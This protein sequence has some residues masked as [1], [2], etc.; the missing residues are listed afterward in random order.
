MF[1]NI[2]Q[3]SYRNQYY[4][5]FCVNL[6][7]VSF[8]FAAGWTAPALLVLS[9]DESPLPSGKLTEQEISNVA[10]IFNL[11][12]FFGNFVHAYL[13]DRYVGPHKIY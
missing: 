11:G 5:T 7:T 10:A 8:G 3:N 1:K 9:S 2:L 4:V 13:A 12:A 6:L